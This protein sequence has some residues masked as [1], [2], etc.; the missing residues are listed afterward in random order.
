MPVQT[1]ENVS[2]DLQNTVALGVKFA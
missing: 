1:L 2:I